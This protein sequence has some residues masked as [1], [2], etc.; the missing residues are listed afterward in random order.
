V[1]RRRHRVG[2][3]TVCPKTL[4]RIEERT[5]YDD[6]VPPK[7]TAPANDARTRCDGSDRP[8]TDSPACR[9]YLSWHFTVLP[10]E[11]IA[12]VAVV[13]FVSPHCEVASC[14]GTSRMSVALSGRSLATIGP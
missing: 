7:P 11:T 6:D 3:L 1:G 13:K 8:R 14:G 12:Q 5:R 4:A 10:A 9:P 2:R